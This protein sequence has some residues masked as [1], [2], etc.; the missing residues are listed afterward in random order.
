MSKWVLIDNIE[1]NKPALINLDT[2][3]D[4]VWSN[5]TLTFEFTDGKCIEIECEKAELIKIAG[6]LDIAAELE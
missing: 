6:T 2:T 3:T 4:V 1:P 5:G